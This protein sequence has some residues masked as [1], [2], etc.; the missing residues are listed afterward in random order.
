M[1]KLYS[2]LFF[3]FLI[4]YSGQLAA[5]PE[6]TFAPSAVISGGTAVCLNSASPI[7][8]FT[9]SGGVAPY[10]FTYKIN[11]GANQTIIANSNTATA[12]VP[13]NAAGEFIYEIVS[14]SDSTNSSQSLTGVTTTFTVGS[15]FTAGFSFNDNACSGSN[16][17]FTPTISGGIAPY[18]YSWNF[19]DGFNSTDETPTHQFLSLGCATEIF[20]VEV[21]ITDAAGCSTTVTQP[22][23]IRQKPHA[24]LQDQDVFY[25]FSNCN[26]NPSTTDPSYTLTLDNTSLDTGCTS[27][28]T[29][30]W[31]D[32]T[33]VMANP[34][35]PLTHT[36]AQLGSYLITF[37]A[38][39]NNGCINVVTYAVANQSNPA[40][41]LGTQG[42]TTGLCAP[43]FVT[44]TIGNWELNS[45]GTQ[46]VVDFGDD[47]TITLSQSDFASTTPGT[48]FI[49]PPHEYTETSCPA[50]SF[51]ATLTVT[52]LCD[53]TPYTAGN[54]Q[55]RVSPSPMFTIP[56][57]GSCVNQPV[58]FTNTT[59]PGSFGNTCSAATTYQWNFGDPASGAG[60]TLTQSNVNT[61]PNATHT[62]SAPGTYTVTLTTS[63]PCGP[64]E[65]FM[66]VCIDPEPVPEFTLDNV[67]GCAPLSVAT[68]N[69][70]ATT[71]CGITY[72][73]S[74]SNYQNTNCG[75]VQ[76]WSFT[77]GTNANSVNPEF[78]FADSGTYTIMLA[79]T[80]SCGTVTTTRTVVVTKPATVIVDDVA[81]QCFGPA[82]TIAPV[83]T[84]T[85]CG[86]TTPTYA[87]NF[88][89]GTPSTSTDAAP[90]VVYSTSGLKT[91]TLTVT[92]E[93]GP[94]E[95]VTKS[96]TI[97]PELIVDAG[98]DITIC[99]NEGQVLSSSVNGG[100]GTG[101]TYNWT[102]VTG[103]SS[104][105]ILNPVATPAVTTTYTLT[106]TDSNNCTLTDDLIVN[107]NAI[108]PGTVAASQT[109]CEGEDPV[110]FTETV[111]A[112][113]PG[114]FTYQW[115]SS[116]DN[117]TFT[118]ISGET[119]STYD[120]PIPTAMIYYRR[121]VISTLNGIECFVPGNVVSVT[122]NNVI[123]SD[124]PADVTICEGGDLAAFIA[125]TNGSGSGTLTY[126]WES[127][128]DNASFTTVGT[129]ATF[130]PPALTQ[131]TYYRQTITSTLNGVAC[132]ATSNVITITVVP[133]PTITAEP[134]ATQSL[135]QGG[136]ITPLSI[137]VTGGAGT[138]PVY[139]YQWYSN[140][141]NS[142]IGGTPLA[143][144]VTAT[145]TP[146]NTTAGTTYYYCI[147]S[148]DGAGCTDTSAVAEV[149]ITPSPTFTTQ[150]V[151]ESLCVGQ[152]PSP[153]TVAYTD[154][155][156][157]PSYQWYSNTINDDTSG[158][159]IAG[160]TTDTYSP[161]ATT[162]TIYY[163]N[164]I[165][166]GTGGCSVITSD[167]AT[168]TINVLPSVVTT[169]SA[170]TCS[171]IAFD[172]TPE[173]GGGNTV[174]VGTAYTWTAPTGTGFT[175]GSAQTSPQSSVSQTL[176]NLTNVPVTVHYQVT[177][178]FNNCE[179]ASF[180]IEITINPTAVIAD[181]ALTICSGTTFN[182]IP[183]GTMPAG[184]T[185]SWNAPTA[186]GIT[187]TVPGNDQISVS[188][189]LDNASTTTAQTVTY[190]V[191]PLSP[192]GDC[193]G[194]PF[195]LN[196]TVNPLFD[197]TGIR[198]DYNGYQVS[199]SGATD[200]SIDITPVGGTGAYTYAW[201]GPGGFTATTQDINN[202]GE[203][204][205]TVTITDG[206]CA[207]IELIFQIAAPLPLTIIEVISSH[208]NV[209]CFGDTTGV[210]EVAI[211]QA[212]VGPYDYVI[213]IDNGL[214]TGA[215]IETVTGTNALNYIFDNLAA[216]TYVVQ[217]TDANNH[218]EE[219]T[220][221]IVNQPDE[222]LAI[223]NVVVSDF[224]GFGISC[225]GAN[226]GSID[227]TVGGGTPGYTY[228]WTSS[229]GFT[230]TTE[231]ISGLAPGDYTVTVNDTEG[232][233]AITQTYTITEPDTV[234]LTAVI[235]DFNGYSI[236]CFGGN[237]GSISITPIGGTGTYTYTWTGTGPVVAGAQNQTDLIAG[238]YN[239]TMSDSNGCAVAQQTYVL[240]QPAEI[241]IAQTH[242]NVIC[243]GDSTGSID[244]TVS[245]GATNY[246]YAW[247]GP[248]G[249]TA[250]T[251]DIINI[252]AGDYTLTVTD[253]SGC[254]KTLNVI[255][256]QQPEIIIVPT[257]T[258]ISCYDANDAS[259]SLAI[260]GGNAPY[261]VTW[262]NLATGTFQDNLSAGSYIITVTDNS[263]CVKTITVVIQ[264]APLFKVTPVVKNITCNGAQDGSIELN[265]EG[266][267]APVTLVWSDG[268]TAG[269]T[270][271]NLGPGTYTAT[272]TDGKPCTII[273]TFIIVEPA[274]L[275]LGA[276]V[277]QPHD[278][279]DSFSGS[280]DLIP[281]GGT[282]P[283][284]IQWTGTVTT[285]DEDLT[286][287][288]SGTYLVTVTDANGCSNTREFTL[289]RP[290][291]LIVSVTANVT[292]NCNSGVVVQVNTASASGGVPPYDFSWSTG[293]TSGN[294]NQNMTTNDNGT[295]VVTVT[296]S[297]GCTANTTFTVATQQLGNPSFDIDSYASGT[298]NLYSIQDPIQFTNTSTGDYIAVSWDF[299]DGSVSDEE[300]PLHTYMRE[301]TYIITQTVTYPYGCVR[302]NKLTIVVEKGYDV[303]VP[304]AF[305]PNGDG[306]NDSFAPQFRGTKSIELNVYDTWGSLVYY[307]KGETIKGWDGNL[308]NT[309]AE[310]GNYVFKINAETFYGVIVT[311]NGPFVLIK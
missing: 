2:I 128:T 240:T 261:T 197:V 169:Q 185:Y 209:V 301:G 217:V 187:G 115:Q 116:S 262:S 208:E 114:T 201:S 236:S 229:N 133:P 52:N 112:T 131:T 142:T 267:I 170:T 198:S 82:V 5:K 32:G 305:T 85:N 290:D 19:G 74:I 129:S 136:T 92:N 107:V 28:Y 7:V 210:I 135:C 226:N 27:N 212:S 255:I 244:A 68:T 91:F 56:V 304:N 310:N 190:V 293:T 17:V 90:S 99:P 123:A 50:S 156:G 155:S 134:V 245:G 59:I 42:S 242:V 202:I 105:A 30:D 120:P 171:G 234:S 41:S 160:A 125:N 254:I 284:T 36:Y 297:K 218:T 278:C 4:L 203:G 88:P 257:T 276:N 65:F 280:I 60:N 100:S 58:T 53:S 161:P 270:R 266:G 275:N 150:P 102:P 77:N 75:T 89:D 159:P 241:T 149:I 12:N 47:T 22:V 13:T 220:G 166:F 148:T 104:S 151:S 8:T 157:T 176:T 274:A 192:P 285:N 272:I 216:A 18:I 69:T 177:P 108:I 81:E 186:T 79:A 175:G 182:Y 97:Q 86:T 288:T 214:G 94:S 147:V 271:N 199:A 164:I 251:E 98:T 10:T 162:G 101:Y 46:Y 225:N 215:I 196:V 248:N 303:M 250:S 106:V 84:V 146:S 15:T 233:C 138:P 308:R 55:I 286:N 121:L 302:T 21:V 11:N 263:G 265:L 153:L 188:G 118:D 64:A 232:L 247:V 103:L 294:H 38:E 287:I 173:D 124:F 195:N 207:P 296:D 259:I 298:Y 144:E 279:D 180:D 184:T 93:C 235:S 282:P 289:T 193:A 191:T 110:A 277:I 253:A 200:G 178:V 119:N 109:V 117:L 300:N 143:S 71:G 78:L 51:T 62:F 194:E 39:G 140:T 154:G 256:T 306:I 205:Y 227:I 34:I 179:G 76:D 181:D 95:T 224:N 37:T 24:E 48:P 221:I 126:I 83:A 311:Y 139:S 307:E 204:T 61:I 163:Y 111:A 299:G 252:K 3:L 273:R 292:A 73:W 172:V 145:F 70:T 211:T 268:S 168:V 189:T 228:Q 80:N 9:G 49:V 6:Y 40:G 230:A 122:I 72:T 213:R 152:T 165:T 57:A 25:P 246:A 31:G 14:I 237:N 29:I 66:E 33:G 63:N 238:T 96:F 291:P 243:F 67:E 167:I 16:V 174:P 269:T 23:T 141:V 43:A 87:W 260:S 54:V 137:T 206:I 35:F 281:G 183:T 309:P 222:A 1:K 158:T 219:L 231:D 26:N 249:F 127:S 258:P 113:A 45:P 132:T 44:F 130:D 223:T 295:V 239:L 283:Y 264:E 20:N